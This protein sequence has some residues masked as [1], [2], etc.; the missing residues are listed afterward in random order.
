MPIEDQIYP[1]YLAVK[2]QNIFCMKTYSSSKGPQPTHFAYY[3][4]MAN[5]SVPQGQRFSFGFK[6]VSSYNGSIMIGIA[7]KSRRKERK[8]HHCGD[9]IAYEGAR[10]HVYGGEKVEKRKGKG[11]EEGDFVIVVVTP[12]IDDK[13][14]V[15]WYVNG[16]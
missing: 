1:Q 14:E 16:K 9:A 6:I 12:Q 7:P 13:I 5:C 4:L 8:S 2:D 3:Q 11:F 15:Q 10:A